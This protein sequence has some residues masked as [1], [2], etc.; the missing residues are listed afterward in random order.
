MD[1][2]RD[3]F[4]VP[5][6]L[7][8]PLRAGAVSADVPAG[9]G[10]ARLGRLRRDPG[11]RRRLRRSP[12]LRHG[13]RRACCSRRRASASASSRSPTGTRR[14]DFAALGEPNLFFGIT[15]GNMDSMVNRYTADRRIRSDDAY[16]PRRRRRARGPT[17]ASS[18]T[19]SAAARRSATS[20]VV[21]G[22][23]E[24]SLRRIAHFDYWSEKVRRSILLDAK[25]DLLVYGNGE[26]QIVEI[27][28]RLAAGQP[29]RDIQRPPRHRLRAR[30]AIARRLDRDRLDHGRHARAARPAR[31]SL[32]GGARHRASRRAATRPRQPP[33]IPVS[34]ADALP[35]GAEPRTARASVVRMPSFEQV[36]A[37][38]VLYAHASRDPAPGVEPGQRARAGAAARRPRRLAQPAAAPAHHGRDG[39]RLRAAL[40]ARARTRATATRRSPPT[41]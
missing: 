39:R 12:E 26:R 31:R 13:D 33:T 5:Q 16:T 8:P 34:V 10:R 6:A 9:D 27:A 30:A 40:P 24:A 18:S 15:A 11:D 22:G 23:I 37:D 1:A 14:A 29:I 36:T 41:R 19:R 35:Q 28:H 21:I 20:P 7:G 3:L 17:A 2:A 4:H 38:P 25:A 32:R